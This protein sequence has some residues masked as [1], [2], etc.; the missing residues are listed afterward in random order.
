V[1]FRSP[2]GANCALT[3][4]TLYPRIKDAGYYGSSYKLP[5]YLRLLALGLGSR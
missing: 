4:V 3:G 2:Y 5:W 1:A